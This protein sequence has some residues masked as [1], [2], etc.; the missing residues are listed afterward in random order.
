MGKRII[1]RGKEPVVPIFKMGNF[2]IKDFILIQDYLKYI[3]NVIFGTELSD[4][5]LHKKTLTERIG[6]IS[7]DLP[8]QPVLRV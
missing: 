6:Q 7:F 4:G 8:W 2:W 5:N 3:G 1:H